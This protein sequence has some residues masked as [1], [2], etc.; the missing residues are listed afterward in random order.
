MEFK[1][2]SENK[3]IN[4]KGFVYTKKQIESYFKRIKLK[5]KLLGYFYKYRMKAIYLA[6]FLII[7]YYKDVNISLLGI[8]IILILKS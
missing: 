6:I 2:I 1:K 7:L 3:Y 4:R 8:C 5:N